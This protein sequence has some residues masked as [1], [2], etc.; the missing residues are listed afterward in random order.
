MR[1]FQTLEHVT[2]DDT[3]GIMYILS[4]E[5]PM[6]SRLALRREGSYIAISTSYGPIE[7]ALRPRFEELTRILARLHPVAGLQ[8]TRQVGTGQAYLGLGLGSDDELIL[9]PTIVADATG[10]IC[11]NLILPKSVREMLYSWLPV[12]ET[13]SAD[14]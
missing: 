14:S 6:P 9:R 12:E 3:A 10:H 1:N 5:Q 2:V 11:F 7:I 4:G 8:T 13:T